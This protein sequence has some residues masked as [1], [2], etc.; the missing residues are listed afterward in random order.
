MSVKTHAPETCVSTNFTTSAALFSLC[1]DCKGKHVKTAFA[2]NRL[3]IF[4]FSSG[5]SQSL[6]G[7]ICNKLIVSINQIP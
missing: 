1:W 3:K 5:K 4:S 2:S 6:S 7:L